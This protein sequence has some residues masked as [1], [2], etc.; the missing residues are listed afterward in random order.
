MGGG[1]ANL[2]VDGEFRIIAIKDIPAGAQ[3][4]NS[5]NQCDYD[6]TCNKDVGLVYM[7]QDIFQDYGFVEQYPR[8]FAFFTGYYNED[9][10][11][12]MVINIDE[13]TSGGG[14]LEVKFLTKR[15]SELQLKWMVKQFARL[16]DKIMID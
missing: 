11:L 10:N 4:Y 15:P 12:G 1:R 14:D 7:T 13:K 16:T 2:E 8:R 5:Y 9:E 6:A 3:L